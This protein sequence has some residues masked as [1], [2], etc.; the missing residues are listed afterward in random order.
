MRSHIH[1]TLKSKITRAGAPNI[2]PHY[3]YSKTIRNPVYVEAPKSKSGT[4]FCPQK[5]PQLCVEFHFRDTITR[6]IG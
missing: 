2:R 1:Y 3:S 6:T 5:I 4:Q